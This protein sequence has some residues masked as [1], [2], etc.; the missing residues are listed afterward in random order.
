MEPKVLLLDEPLS[1]LDIVSKLE[2]ISYFRDV[3]NTLQIPII[4]VTHHPKEAFSLADR[5]VIL[6]NGK[7]IEE[8]TRNEVMLKPKTKF[9]KVI[10]DNL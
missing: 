2:L 1:N 9:A 8:G 3:F 10:M 6:N 5:I 4:Y 7:V